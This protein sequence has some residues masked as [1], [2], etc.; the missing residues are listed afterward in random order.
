MHKEVLLDRALCLSTTEIAAL[1]EG[2]SI[3]VIS[4]VAIK[5]GWQFALYP[6]FDSEPDV[7]DTYRPP[8][9]N[10]RNW[11]QTADVS[12]GFWA[13][14]ESFQ[15]LNDAEHIKALSSSTIWSEDHLNRLL[16]ERLRLF[17]AVLRVAKIPDKIL[18]R[19][20]EV[21]KDKSEKFLGFYSLDEKMREPLRVKEYIPIL[22]E[23]IFTW[24]KDKIRSFSPFLY[25]ELEDIYSAINDLDTG[26]PESE[27][28]KRQIEYF[29]GWTNPQREYGS[30]ADW[31]RT[32]VP[33]GNRSI[34]EEKG[35]KS[36]Y[37]AGTDF[38]NIVH[39]SLEFLG[40]KVDAAY[41]GGA[42]GLDLFCSQPYP[43]TGECKA[44][45][46]IPSG[47]TQELI[48]LGGMRL[49]QEK[50]LHS[51]KLII[52]PGQPTPDVLTAAMEWKVSI[53]SPMTLQKLVELQNKY[54]GSVNLIELK[55]YLKP[56]QINFSEYIDKVEREIC[57][58][59]HVVK[60]IRD[61]L[62]QQNLEH[63]SFE[64]FCGVFDSSAPP[65]KLSDEDLHDVLVELSSPLVGSLGRIK[66]GD[67]RIDRF[68]YIRDLVIE[69]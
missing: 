42:G 43:L 48:K 14:C 64:R 29:M 27:S 65:T 13:S 40:F 51:V 31:I 54:P 32:I 4:K 18:F 23:S 39:K 26:V 5:E 8:F 20:Q 60:A 67:W 34:E 24:R 17:I 63:V 1:A 28:I 58:R 3:A 22:N 45:K 25:S 38:E 57:L 44:G 69:E 36:N 9:W 21:S 6:I 35:Q 7:K 12:V 56:G 46:K 61:Y 53:I 10:L 47:T 19:N 37:Q 55:E 33:L 49:G 66:S 30:K 15:V 2:K 50:F 62:R 68:Y 16:K 52:G 11:E 41:K 59:A